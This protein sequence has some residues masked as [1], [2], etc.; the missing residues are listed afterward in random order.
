MNHRLA[1]VLVAPQG[2]ANIGAAARAMKN[3]GVTDLRLV[4]PVPFL[5]DEAYT[6]A[7]DAKDLLHSARVCRNLDEALS[8]LGFAAAFTRRFGR[9]RKRH[10][11]LSDAAG[12]I[13]RRASDG[14]AALV[15]GREDAGLTNDEISRCDMTVGIP[16]S[17]E[18]PSINLAQSVLLA[19]Y[20]STRSGGEFASAKTTDERVVS[21]NE[22]AE[23]MKRM[24]STL[25]SLGYGNG[26]DKTLPTSILGRWER[27]FGRAGLTECDA[28]M[29]EGLLTRIAERTK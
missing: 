6:W 5:N 18:F 22:V 12:P 24:E 8:D 14:G 16:T 29:L 23:I 19:C 15:F 20:E 1:I 13:S 28:G 4:D 2:P 17:D 25:F 9:S 3:F 26:P 11:S 27:I 10:A 21:R 7:C